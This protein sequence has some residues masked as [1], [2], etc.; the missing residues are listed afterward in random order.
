VA[1]AGQR[2]GRLLVACRR[3]RAAG[4]PGGPP[5]RR[6]TLCRAQGADARAAAAQG[7]FYFA[8]LSAPEHLRFSPLA[9]SSV[10]FSVDNDLVRPR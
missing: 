7:R 4:A 5:R 2:T 8:V 1:E 9:A 3:A 6:V 10:C